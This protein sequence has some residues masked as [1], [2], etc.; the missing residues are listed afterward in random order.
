MGLQMAQE[1]INAAGG[2]NGRPIELIIEDSKTVPASAVTAYR[3]LVTQN[4]V[5]VVIGDV[6]DFITNPMVPLAQR[7]KVL[8]LS[9]TTMPHALETRSRSVFTAGHRTE[10]IASAVDHFFVVNP[11]VK[12]VG[13]LCWDDAWGHAYLKVWREAIERNG[14]TVAATVCN[15]DFATD[16]R[17]DVLKVAAAKV[18]AIFIAH[19]A[20]VA[21]KRIKEQGLAPV[22][23]TSSN[24]V[25]DLKVKQAP[26]E[27][28]EG[29][30]FTDWRPSE[31][32]VA[33]FTSRF[34]KEPVCEAHNSYEALR[35][36]AKALAINSEDPV[37]ALR[38]VRYQG[39]EGMLDFSDPVSASQTAARL[40]T[41]RSGEIVEV[42][43]RGAVKAD[44]HSAA[45]QKQK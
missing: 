25:E 15:V 7:D 42:L 41:V 8:L 34:G 17:T 36:V 22:I 31:D 6:W 28:F 18:D 45:A 23:L 37:S 43:L 12:R 32:F 40:Y 13:I 20:D 21:L 5:K 27:L 33:A 10:Q 44:E 11:K 1:E 24:V 3:K 30:Y 2:V 14:A 26:P 9:P 35:A 29:I 38:Q 4:K 39:V 16:Y 19:L